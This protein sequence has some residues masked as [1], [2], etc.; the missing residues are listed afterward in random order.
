MAPFPPTL[1]L[2]DVEVDGQP[3]LTELTPKDLSAPPVEWT[4]L[5][6]IQDATSA[7]ARCGQV[8]AL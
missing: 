4:K 2:V 5:E 8:G 3:L 6:V 7:S 1:G